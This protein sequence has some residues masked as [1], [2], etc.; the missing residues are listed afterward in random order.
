MRSLKDWIILLTC[1]FSTLGA[2]AEREYKFTLADIEPYVI[3]ENVPARTLKGLQVELLQLLAR[4]ID[5][6]ISF[7]PIP[8]RRYLSA[9]FKQS[10]DGAIYSDLLVDALPSIHE[11]YEVI[12][13]VFASSMI[14]FRR[15]KSPPLTPGSPI[16]DGIVGQVGDSCG[17][18]IR[19]HVAHLKTFDIKDPE[20]GVLM[21]YKDRL[22]YLCLS[23]V[24]VNRLLHKLN[25]PKGEFEVLRDLGDFHLL[26]LLR[27]DVPDEEKSLFRE[28]V[29]SGLK[30]GLFHELY[31][32]YQ[33]RNPKMKG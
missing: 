30:R 16:P 14:L 25:I 17:V 13:P 29:R 33:V 26:L 23:D 32:R 24:V 2:S 1:L 19:K 28:A 15:M 21:L 12:A 31:E 6:P 10:Y 9:A 3:R 11:N 20:Q 18:F 22:D 4:E 27:K 7:V 5:R 8:T